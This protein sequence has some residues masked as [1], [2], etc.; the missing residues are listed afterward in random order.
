MD[1]REILLID[2][3]SRAAS[4]LAELDNLPV[5]P[6]ESAVQT[7]KAFAQPFPEHPTDP[8][9]IL[10]E[11]DE[12]GRIA[13]VSNAGGRYFGF[14]CGGTVP[15]ALA[16]GVLV[17]AW[18]QNAGLYVAS[19]IAAELEQVALDW[20]VEVLGLPDGTGS[21]SVMPASANLSAKLAM[22][23]NSRRYF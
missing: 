1:T 12:A 6:S 7:L 17:S 8:A 3:A 13:A 10:A 2:A 23:S 22:P 19:P 11:L 14:V 18:D 16:A 5:G 15:A 21:V 4:Y 9:H 20:V